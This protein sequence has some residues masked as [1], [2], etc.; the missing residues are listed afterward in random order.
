MT[1]LVRLVL[2]LMP[3]DLRKM[4]LAAGLD[5][6]ATCRLQ[7]LAELF[8][9]ARKS[10]GWTSPRAAKVTGI[11]RRTIDAAESA[12]PSRLD[13]EELIAYSTR[14]G[15]LHL[16]GEW[17]S[18]N[19]R[20]ATAL[21]LPSEDDVLSRGRQVLAEDARQLAVLPDTLRSIAARRFEAPAG[22]SDHL[23]PDRAE[24]RLSELL[25][26]GPGGPTP[27]GGKP[28]A[29]PL[30]RKPS[31][32][33]TY[34]LHVQ[35]EGVE[36]PVWRRIR[37][38]NTLTFRQL[39]EVLQT[40]MGWHDAHL[41]GFTWRDVEIGRPDPEWQHPLLDESRVTLADLALRARS[42]LC[43][44]YDFGDDWKHEIRLERILP[45]APG[46]IPVC[47]EGSGGCP[48]EDCGGPFAYTAMIEA[49]HHPESPTAAELLEWAGPNW[50][51]AGFEIEPVNLL[52]A[53]LARSW[54]RHR[55]TPA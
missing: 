18:A 14:L 50:R 24:A 29:G 49:F 25:A 1:R 15:T 11:R 45:P 51:P 32:P 17:V 10:R 55:R 36:P 9:L 54:R 22:F 35:L 41:H 48:P 52:L 37:V 13:P 46:S 43:Y 42:K 23:D 3:A 53:R 39:H 38:P 6:E 47:V 4:T 33:G 7:P 34:E 20:L 31:P 8:S 27:A 40:V 19:P 2:N 16:L 28:S 26:L 21:G 30:P 12:N 5:V 44:R